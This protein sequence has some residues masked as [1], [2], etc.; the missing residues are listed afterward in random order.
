MLHV[1]AFIQVAKASVAAAYSSSEGCRKQNGDQRPHQR[2]VSETCRCCQQL[3]ACSAVC[4]RQPIA[5]FI[6]YCTP[7][8]YASTEM[9]RPHSCRVY[10]FTHQEGNTHTKRPS[11]Q[12]KI[13]MS[14]E[15]LAQL[16][17]GHLETMHKNIVVIC[18]DVQLST[19]PQVFTL[20]QSYHH[21]V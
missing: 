1:H 19:S 2:S 13:L 4:E 3:R 14:G 18:Q 17:V 11:L 21:M 15:Y 20:E 6:R 9:V 5:N 7:D 12:Y 8:T 16:S 10:Y